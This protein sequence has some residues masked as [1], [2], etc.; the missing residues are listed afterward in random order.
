MNAKERTRP[1]EVGLRMHFG[2]SRALIASHG[3]HD[4]TDDFS[5]LEESDLSSMGLHEQSFL[6]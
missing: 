2:D 1:S 5:V 3:L 4:G 6:S